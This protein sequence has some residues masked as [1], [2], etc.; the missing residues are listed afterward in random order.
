MADK[1]TNTSYDMNPL[2]AEK[3]QAQ[4]IPAKN[5]SEVY[6]VGLNQ[7]EMISLDDKLSNLSCNGDNHIIPSILIDTPTG[8]K[9]VILTVSNGQKQC[10]KVIGPKGWILN[11][12]TILTSYRHKFSSFISRCSS[13]STLEGEVVF[14]ECLRHDIHPATALNEMSLTSMNAIEMLNS[15]IGIVSGKLFSLHVSRINELISLTKGL[16]DKLKSFVNLVTSNELHVLFNFLINVPII[17][18]QNT[19][20]IL[21][22]DLRCETMSD[23]QVSFPPSSL[24]FTSEQLAQLRV[25]S[26]AGDPVAIEIFKQK[27]FKE[28][29]PMKAAKPK[30]E[31]K[32]LTKPNDLSS[33]SHYVT[34]IGATFPPSP[35]PYYVQFSLF[36]V[37]SL[38][39][40]NEYEISLTII[41]QFTGLYDQAISDLAFWIDDVQNNVTIPDY[42]NYNGTTRSSALC[43]LGLRSIISLS[44]ST[45]SFTITKKKK[46]NGG[47]SNGF[48][49]TM[50]GHLY[51][52]TPVNTGATTLG[53]TGM[54]DIVGTVQDD[55]RLTAIDM[56]SQVT[57]IKT[58][59][60]SAVPL[61]VNVTN[62]TLLVDV[63]NTPLPIIITNSTVPVSIAGNVDTT[64]KGIAFS[65]DTQI[66]TVYTQNIGTTEIWEQST[67]N[68]QQIKYDHTG[69][70]PN[71]KDLCYNMF[72]ILKTLPDT[73]IDKVL[74]DDD[75]DVGPNS[76]VNLDPASK[77]S[78]I[79]EKKGEK[80]KQI[81]HAVNATF[82]KKIK[83]KDEKKA[84]DPNKMTNQE[85]NGIVD[86]LVNAGPRSSKDVNT[87]AATQID[88][89]DKQ[90]E[91]TRMTGLYKAALQRSKSII[92]ASSDQ[93]DRLNNFCKYYVIFY[94]LEENMDKVI[95]K[96]YLK[97]LLFLLDLDAIIPLIER[98]FTFGELAMLCMAI[99]INVNM[100]QATD[101]LFMDEVQTWG[102]GKS[103]GDYCV[104]NDF[105][106]G[107]K[108]FDEINLAVSGSKVAKYSHM[109]KEPNDSQMS[110]EEVIDINEQVEEPTLLQLVYPEN[111][112]ETHNFL[113]DRAQLEL[114][115]LREIAK[116]L[117][118]DFVTIEE[119]NNFVRSGAR[120]A[121]FIDKFISS[122]ANY[123]DFTD[124]KYLGPGYT[125]G[126]FDSINNIS[127]LA[128]RFAVKPGSDLDAIARVHDLMRTLHTT[129]QG[130][131][132]ADQKMLELIDTMKDNN[133]QSAASRF[134]IKNLAVPYSRH[135][136]TTPEV[137]ATT[138]IPE[139]L[140]ILAEAIHNTKPFEEMTFQEFMQ[141]RKNRRLGPTNREMHAMNGNTVSADKLKKMIINWVDKFTSN[142][143]NSTSIFGYIAGMSQN[144]LNNADFIYWLNYLRY[145]SASSTQKLIY[146]SFEA[147]Q[148]VD[149]Y[150]GAPTIANFIFAMGIN[151]DPVS[152][153]GPD[154]DCGPLASMFEK[155]DEEDLT[156][157]IN[158]MRTNTAI[159]SATTN[160]GVWALT[161]DSTG[162]GHMIGS[163]SMMLTKLW[164]LMDQMSATSEF[165]PIWNNADDKYCVPR[166]L[167]LV[168]PATYFPNYGVANIVLRYWAMTQQQFISLNFL[169]TNI[170]VPNFTQSKAIYIFITQDLLDVTN[171]N[172]L[173]LM[174]ASNLPFPLLHFNKECNYFNTALDQQANVFQS[175][176]NAA[177]IDHFK[178][179]PEIDAL[180]RYFNVVFIVAGFT[181][182]T[183][184][185]GWDFDFTVPILGGISSV[186]NNP[187]RNADVPV[188]DNGVGPGTLG[189]AIRA[190]S[191]QSSGGAS[192]IIERFWADY[193]G[194]RDELARA[195]YLYSLIKF[196][197]VKTPCLHT[198]CDQM[199]AGNNIDGAVVNRAGPTR[200]VGQANT[201][202]GHD[203]AFQ[204]HDMFG[205][206]SRDQSLNSPGYLYSQMAPK[207]QLALITQ[208]RKIKIDK[209]SINGVPPLQPEQRFIYGLELSCCFA[210]IY[211]KTFAEIGIPRTQYYSYETI[212]VGPNQEIEM[213][214][215]MLLRMCE[216]M[217]YG[218][219]VQR[220]SLP[221][222]VGLN[223]QGTVYDSYSLAPIIQE[224]SFTG[225]DAWE[226]DEQLD[227]R[228][229]SK[230]VSATDMVASNSWQTS[231]LGILAAINNFGHHGDGFVFNIQE[232]LKLWQPNIV[233]LGIDTSFANYGLS[234]NRR[235]FLGNLNTKKAFKIMNPTILSSGRNHYRQITDHIVGGFAAVTDIKKIHVYPALTYHYPPD[236]GSDKFKMNIVL[237]PE[238]VNLLLNGSLRL[239][240]SN[241]C[242]TI[243]VQLYPS[244]TI[245]TNPS[246]L[247]TFIRGR[248]KKT[249][250]S[251]EEE[252]ILKK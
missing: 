9:S 7:P 47:P 11:L 55:V 212:N 183:Q 105:P 178:R 137:E 220:K 97:R 193:Y 173:Y 198:S 128:E 8:T 121:N 159:T 57:N 214:D 219:F 240:Q 111:V 99:M 28:N 223:T 237:S 56:S 142:T 157:V 248:E 174:I 52:S 213:Q 75:N 162:N 90:Y 32:H 246:T 123:G 87:N 163:N 35:P 228:D 44:S 22:D 252:S 120:E 122:L 50:Y 71:D 188:V 26:D 42:L 168:Q 225:C 169:T 89:A 175:T 17:W 63:D 186:G 4:S 93:K 98:I 40:F 165:S 209:L 179:I 104:R 58:T 81:G 189:P 211:S 154:L 39:E 131:E 82:G 245:T 203:T 229:C 83:K 129:T 221:W 67:P 133:L 53:I 73:F 29:P 70:E 78:I 160:L 171:L 226:K 30:T 60:V 234:A 182:T 72:E 148:P 64:I 65:N 200:L 110:E 224:L 21:I 204:F 6:S 16:I 206:R 59:L 106:I 61:D 62:T 145:R 155:A 205:V 116:E 27:C 112:Y 25:L 126:S 114:F 190:M 149:G 94:T 180:V 31:D 185:N 102:A 77:Q 243:S 86:S 92:K 74:Q 143:D 33:G 2:G 141:D 84:Q 177:R 14:N 34:S 15:Q 164:L 239:F 100:D 12:E 172:A 85:F 249:I 125:G 101:A 194:S 244:M 187:T 43:Q 140:T 184:N 241:N 132:R 158:A 233:L 95:S 217:D 54:I 139:P 108:I 170:Q 147:Q 76:S 107:Q 13:L 79:E 49:N 215:E 19:K 146:T 201:N 235:I 138:Y 197:F 236:T 66:S 150:T 247:N 202:N 5:K 10:L 41:A 24:Y 195:F 161:R 127:Q 156:K 113:N 250:S 152:A 208:I 181:G 119:A 38:L 69:K 124:N 1:H 134:V 51:I 136:M 48:K 37:T 130:H 227:M 118:K 251:T 196:R 191:L 207:Y 153:I 166:N 20:T 23:S 167:A 46:Q 115:A 242:N 151:F 135:I 218:N 36:P 80:N 91:R 109:G 216:I 144:T 238:M 68:R 199:T 96:F 88:N 45:P 176:T 3:D 210:M 192:R 231:I 230:I 222:N 103:L 232:F 18:F 117:G